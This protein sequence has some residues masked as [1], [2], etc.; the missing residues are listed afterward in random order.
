MTH[1]GVGRSYGMAQYLI[2][3]AFAHETVEI[4][5]EGSLKDGLKAVWALAAERKSE[6]Y[7]I[8]FAKGAVRFG[9]TE[10]GWT[11]VCPIEPM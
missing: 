11:T 6:P 4:E 10:D 8:R 2:T 3:V 7:D 5:H 1:I 9:E